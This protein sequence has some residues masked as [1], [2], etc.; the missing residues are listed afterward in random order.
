[1]AQDLMKAAKEDDSVSSSLSDNDLR[2]LA[3][4]T[5]LP[6][7]LLEDAKAKAGLDG[8]GGP[9]SIP[10][11]GIGVKK[12]EVEFK[13]YTFD[14]MSLREPAPES[15]PDPAAMSD[16]LEELGG[17]APT[18]ATTQSRPE[19]PRLT[20][21]SQERAANWAAGPH[22]PYGRNEPKANPYTAGIGMGFG[23]GS[24]SGTVLYSGAQSYSAAPAISSASLASGGAAMMM[25]DDPTVARGTQDYKEFAKEFEREFGKD[26]MSQKEIESMTKRVE[27]RYKSLQAFVQEL[28]RGDVDMLLYRNKLI[29][30]LSDVQNDLREANS[31]VLVLMN[32]RANMK[33]T[34]CLLQVKVKKLKSMNKTLQ[35]D[36]TKYGGVSHP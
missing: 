13:P 25:S 3:A 6:P 31:N 1:M 21:D 20:A 26:K 28:E 19:L 16:P 2:D 36:I 8:K 30:E 32:D 22:S 5:G 10:F 4:Q 34:F 27:V 12:P 9:T 18:T 35:E 29:R 33:D 11:V 23:S 14:P 17:L 15:N 7:T 24:G